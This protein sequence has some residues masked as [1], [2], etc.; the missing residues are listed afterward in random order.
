SGRYSWN[1]QKGRRKAGLFN[2]FWRQRRSVL[3]DDRAAEAVVHPDRSHFH[4]LTDIVASRDG[5]GRC[6]ERNVAVAHEQ[7]V[8]FNRNR[9][10]R[11]KA[12]FNSRSY[13]ATPTGIARLII[14]DT[15]CGEVG[16]VFV[17]GDGSAALHI[18][19]NV[20]PGV[21]DL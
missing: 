19:E 14:H 11:C 17:V 13:S 6:R 16:A 3:R 8:V 1:K 15:G 20:V 18:P 2:L 9:P 12:E 7:M 4:A 21:A 10:V 5:N